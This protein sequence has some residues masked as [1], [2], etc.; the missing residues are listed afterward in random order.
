MDCF[1]CET[2]CINCEELEVKVTYE[3]DVARLRD[4]RRNLMQEKVKADQSTSGICADWVSA[5]VGTVWFLIASAVLVTVPFFVPALM[6]VIGYISSGYMQLLLPILIMIAANRVDKV[7][8]AKSEREYRI[9][10]VS[11]RIDELADMKGA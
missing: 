3:T 1:G 5:Q 2:R 7:R 8:E 4:I 9:L 10:L 6:T 11:D